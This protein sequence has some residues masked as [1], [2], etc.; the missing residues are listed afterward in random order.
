MKE[1]LINWFKGQDGA[2]IAFSGGVDSCV[3]AA[4]AREALGKKAI[5]VTS[6]SKTFPK[7]ELEH[8]KKAAREIGIKHEI[9]TE[10]ELENPAF[11]KNPTD[12]CYHCRKGLIEGVKAI[13]E[14]YNI[15]TIVDGAN[16][17]DTGEH[18]PGM[19]AMKEADVKS[20]LLELGITKDKV[21]KI[22]GEFGLSV[23]EKPAMA[24]LASRVPYGERITEG[25]LQKIEKA[26]NI[27]KGLGISQMRVRHHES[28]AR[29]EVMPEDMPKVSE[30][31]AQI[32]E[33]FKALG[34]AYVTL[35]IKG[36][37]SG[38]MDE[39]L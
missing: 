22:A 16:A 17:S 38:S 20:P 18:R 33:K 1:K 13:A 3:V 2:V 30:N 12:R 8:A 23:K 27:L 5:A 6:D 7:S 25:K 32:V 31:K 15:T 26:E 34:F 37:R 4:A 14:R 19:K 21:R 29:I 24:C 39:I 9:F 10:N 28:L 36:Y 11:V 35:D